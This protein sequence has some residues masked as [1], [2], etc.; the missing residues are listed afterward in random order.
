MAHDQD[1]HDKD[2]AK[3]S[4]DQQQAICPD[5][6]DAKIEVLYEAIQYVPNVGREL[7]KALDTLAKAFDDEARRIAKKDKSNLFCCFFNKKTE[8]TEE[9][10]TQEKQKKLMGGICLAITLIDKIRQYNTDNTGNT[11]NAD[12][13]CK[14]LNDYAKEAPGEKNCPRSSGEIEN[15]RNCM[16]TM[17]VVLPLLFSMSM[18]FM[19]ASGFVSLPVG[20]VL[21]MLVL[22]VSI[23][24]LSPDNHDCVHT[25]HG[26]GI[27]RRAQEVS[28]LTQRFLHSPII[29][30]ADRPTSSHR[31][32][33]SDGLTPVMVA[34][35]LF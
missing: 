10:T 4:V 24:S 30:P 22:P 20:I 27:A 9:E 26:K 2:E 11:D 29:P 31:A 17:Q 13:A 14:E 23:V 19:M 7:K 12:R 6:L 25:K 34:A 15:I 33:D 16:G 3:K 8:E 32:C 18:L 5:D 21:L 1:T 28:K 35:A